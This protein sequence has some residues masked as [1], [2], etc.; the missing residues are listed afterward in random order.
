[1]FVTISAT[2]TDD[3]S[4]TKVEFFANGSK[5]GEDTVAP[6]SMP[7]SSAPGSYVLVARATDSW[8]AVTDSAPRTIT[9]NATPTA[10]ITSPA[11]M[12][13]HYVQA[14]MTVTAACRRRRRHRSA[15]GILRGSTS[16]GVDTTSPYSID[17]DAY[18]AGGYTLTA[19]A[20]DNLGHTGT[21]GQVLVSTVTNVHC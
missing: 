6:Y 17:V 1:M 10:T 7:W 13:Q 20:T 19:V 5:I 18:R 11:N 9:I 2:A 21:S 3:G 16:L 8:G 4:V 14:P 15:G 12:S